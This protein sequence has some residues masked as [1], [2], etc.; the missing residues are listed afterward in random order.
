ME[1]IVRQ[2]QE[3]LRA[4]ASQS[5]NNLSQFTA[6][7]GS[8]MSWSRWH[9]PYE[10]VAPFLTPGNLASLAR[11]KI[12]Q[13]LLVNLSR[14]WLRTEDRF[15]FWE[16]ILSAID[17]IP[18]AW[19]AEIWLDCATSSENWTPRERNGCLPY[20]NSRNYDREELSNFVV[21]SKWLVDAPLVRKW[22]C[23]LHKPGF[24]LLNYMD[25]KRESNYPLRD[26]L[27]EV[28]RN[29]DLPSFA[30]LH[31]MHGEVARR[32]LLKD[33]LNNNA[34]AI[35]SWMVENNTALIARLKP[36]HLMVY[37]AANLPSATAIH[38]IKC[39]ENSFPGTLASRDIF[40][41]NLLWYCLHNKHILWFS[42]NSRLVSFLCDC[43]CRRDSR[44]H[45]GLSL[46]DISKAMTAGQKKKAT[47]HAHLLS[48][49]E[50]WDDAPT[51]VP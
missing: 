11:Q 3:A 37:A 29:D 36:Y 1:V 33:V 2:L 35:F 30:L 46:D 20:Y 22:Y 42:A 13:K 14:N 9:I 47:K 51:S 21:S 4:Y 5:L 50:S 43:G 40:G 28:I 18:T 49:P 45:L 12:S 8:K 31:T 39:L 34:T 25:G 38:A 16:D 6:P 7:L 26:K 17:I 24:E 32:T 27:Q 10:V 41:N 48:S 19:R 23:R 44:N 15:L